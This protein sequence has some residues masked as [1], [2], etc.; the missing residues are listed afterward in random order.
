MGKQVLSRT[1]RYNKKYGLYEKLLRVKVVNF[2]SYKYSAGG[3]VYFPMIKARGLKRLKMLHLRANA[4][5]NTDY[6]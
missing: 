5:K 6:I 1:E 2:S 3:H 4:A